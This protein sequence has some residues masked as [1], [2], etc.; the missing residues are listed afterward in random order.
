[1]ENLSQ[2]LL[3]SKQKVLKEIV[4]HTEHKNMHIQLIKRLVTNAYE[5]Y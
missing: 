2:I 5:Y 3:K 4:S 1:M